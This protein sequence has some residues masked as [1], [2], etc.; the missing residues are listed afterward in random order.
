MKHPNSIKGVTY[1]NNP[2]TV[3]HQWFPVEY[4]SGSD[5]T[6]Y[7]GDTFL[8]E[9]LAIEFT[10]D[11]RVNPIFGYASRTW[12]CAAR[13]ARYVTGTFEIPFTEA[14]YL[15]AIITHIG[16]YSTENEK[17]KPKMAYLMADEEVPGWCADIKMDLEGLFD[18]FD[19]GDGGKPTT[20]ATKTSTKAKTFVVGA[21]S[22]E[23]VALKTSLTKAVGY[24]DTPLSNF[25]YK[26]YGSADVAVCSKIEGDFINYD[27][28]K[29]EEFYKAIQET[30]N[31][32]FECDE[33]GRFQ[34]RMVSY[35]SDALP[36][37]REFSKLSVDGIYDS[38]TSYSL[39]TVLN[40]FGYNRNK[41]EIVPSSRYLNS[42]KIVITKDIL[43]L[44]IG[45][46]CSTKYDIQAYLQAAALQKNLGY[47]S[48]G[49]LTPE[50][51]ATLPTDDIIGSISPEKPKSSY[52]ENAQFTRY[53]E[54]MGR[55]ESEIWGRNM[56]ADS[57]HKYQTFFYTDRYRNAGLDGAAILKKVGFDIYITYGP[58]ADAQ[59]YNTYHDPAGTKAKAID[60]YGFSTTVK[61]IR[62]VQI[63]S[64]TQRVAASG[65][66]IS[67]IYTFMAQD[68]D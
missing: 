27:N 37:T 48:T 13:G 51:Y 65:A 34:N 22:K 30:L 39:Q 45:D 36:I 63:T 5:V 23:V 41:I 56:S 17:V 24:V 40:W 9:C 25:M 49:E 2:N 68:L 19:K 15:E 10:I 67:E 18:K 14:G 46:P 50:Q 35:E 11:E 4:F 59:K 57:D 6:I 43:A 47:M 1:K 21:N 54:R 32:V 20:P 33:K 8:S 66:P 53:Q 58:A 29:T 42:D 64:C 31:I 62:N 7:F 28:E 16:E 44:L 61:A 26:Y 55:Y 38:V 12:D 3:E 52:G 60:T